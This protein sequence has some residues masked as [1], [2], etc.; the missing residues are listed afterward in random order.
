MGGV[1]VHD[2]LRL[3]RYSLQRALKYKKYY[4]S[5]FFG[6]LDLA[7]VNAFIVFNAR[8]EADG[9]KKLS[10]VKFLKQ[11]HLE[12]AQLQDNREL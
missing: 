12:L 5:L 3:Q 4:K 6:F 11:L 8:C 2:Q 7:I 1:D 10:H 9:A